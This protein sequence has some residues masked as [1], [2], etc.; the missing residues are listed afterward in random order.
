MSKKTGVS[1]EPPQKLHLRYIRLPNHVLELYD[2]L[3]YRSER[4]IVG[5]AQIASEHSV[6]FDGEIVLAPGFEIVYFDFV[7]KW[8]T[9]GKIRNMQGKH[10]GYYCDIV[11]PP[12]LLEDGGLELTDLFLDLWVSPDL[13]YEVLDEAELEDALCNGW[14][15]KQL[16]EK[17]KEELNKLIQIVKRGKFPP[18][19][20]KCLEKKLQI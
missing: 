17:A 1:Q 12:R 3:V 2:G 10:T 4:V 19:Q 5:K 13:R 18:Y 14:V 8:F 15:S 20:V 9:V 16:C 11:T 7:G 6:I